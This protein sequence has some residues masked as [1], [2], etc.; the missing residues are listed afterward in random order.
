MKLGCQCDIITQWMASTGTVKLREG[1]FT[2]LVFMMN[3]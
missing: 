3:L 1:S 2:A